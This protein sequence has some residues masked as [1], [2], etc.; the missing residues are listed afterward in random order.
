MQSPPCKSYR[1]SMWFAVFWFAIFWWVFERFQP[2][3][4][5]AA[6]PPNP[7]PPQEPLCALGI[8]NFVIEQVQLAE[9]AGDA[10]L[11][12]LRT[13]SPRKSRG[14]VQKR[15][16]SRS[17]PQVFLQFCDRGSP[18]SGGRRGCGPAAPPNR[19]SPCG[20]RR[21]IQ[22]CLGRDKHWI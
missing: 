10:G 3:E 20:G 8:C 18:A 14:A 7:V 2:A 16:M 19:F 5:G 21:V 12:P 22:N 1:D 13:P 4:A 11:P 17:V 15:S 9:A 6:A